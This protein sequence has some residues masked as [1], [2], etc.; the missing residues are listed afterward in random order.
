MT[1]EATTDHP[2]T[3][4]GRISAPV[5]RVRFWSGL[6]ARLRRQRSAI[7]LSVVIWSATVALGASASQGGP[8]LYSRTADLE[9]SALWWDVFGTN[10][11]IAL[12]LFSGVVLLGVTTILQT[13]VTGTLLGAMLGQAH[14]DFAPSEIV[15]HVGPHLVPEIA[16]LVLATAAGLTTLVAIARRA[17]GWTRRV[18]I[19]Q[20]L[21]DA[22]ALLVVALVSL[23]L[24]AT[25]ETWI[26]A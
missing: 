16:G 26:S 12:G 3:T 22:L 14:A 13:V 9:A 15:A 7:V 10:A 2:P 24:A 11:A 1:H 6:V 4:A 23:L 20:A 19:G 17:G 5:A 25:L 21:R 18:A 8:P